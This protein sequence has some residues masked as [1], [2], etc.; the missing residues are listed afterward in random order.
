MEEQ[1]KL[2]FQT[3]ELNRQ[4]Y[5][6]FG[7]V[8]NIDWEGEWLIVWQQERCGKSEEVHKVMKEDLAGG[9]CRRSTLGRMRL[10]G[11]SWCCL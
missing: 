6:I 1:A 2:P 3:L 10:G 5:K 4:R 9:S 8:T 11:G 7:I